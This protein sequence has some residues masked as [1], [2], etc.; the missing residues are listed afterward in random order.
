MTHR[1]CQ[2]RQKKKKKMKK[3][4]GE[5][6]LEAG[7]RPASLELTR[8]SPIEE[9]TPNRLSN[10]KK[11]KKVTL[12]ADT[13]RNMQLHA[14]IQKRSIQTDESLNFH[15]RAW[16]LALVLQAVQRPLA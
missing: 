16:I 3:K 5:R 13:M 15:T 11:R 4:S 14:T 10:E 7:R 12:L 2:L 8:G 6:S 1:R 9:Q